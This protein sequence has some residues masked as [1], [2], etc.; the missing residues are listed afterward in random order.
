MR[1][2]RKT[3]P[4]CLPEAREIWSDQLVI[5]LTFESDWSRK[6]RSFSRPITEQGKPKLEQIRITFGLQLKIALMEY[7]GN[8]YICT[9]KVNTSLLRRRWLM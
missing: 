4:N 2:Q 7:Y 3:S 9:I 8:K 1:T 5:G 6:W